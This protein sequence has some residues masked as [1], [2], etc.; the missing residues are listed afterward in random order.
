MEEEILD[1]K[2]ELSKAEQKRDDTVSW[3]EEDAEDSKKDELL[4]ENVSLRLKITEL[5][6]EVGSFE[7]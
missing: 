1:L 7:V 6:R 2:K 4:T 3:G 5:E